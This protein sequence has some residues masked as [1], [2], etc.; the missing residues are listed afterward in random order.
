MNYEE[1]RRILDLPT[2]EERRRR[3]D[4]IEMFK[5]KNSPNYINFEDPL[6]YFDNMSRGRHNKRLHREAVKTGNMRS[7][8]YFLTNRVVDDWNA[9]TQERIDSTNKNLFKNRIDKT[10]KF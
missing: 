3:G 1:R 9:L 10:L 8:H 7:R 2:L 5:I 4:L 6:R